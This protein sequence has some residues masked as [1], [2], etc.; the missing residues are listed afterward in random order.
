MPAGL[1]SF[2]TGVLRILEQ[3]EAKEAKTG[4]LGSFGAVRFLACPIH[5]LHR[6][7]RLP[8]L[9]TKGGESLATDEHGRTQIAEG[10]RE[11]G[12]RLSDLVAGVVEM[13][14]IAA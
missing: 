6:L 8:K 4:R 5:R 11:A 13:R 12:A 9:T 3:K 10:K 7:H 2:G 1:G 14:K